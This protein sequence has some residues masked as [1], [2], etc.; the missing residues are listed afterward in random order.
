MTRLLLDA[1]L[2]PR[3]A[4]YLVDRF[5]LDVVSLLTLG[6]GHLDDLHV[7][8]FAKQQRR[9]LITFDA[10]FGTLYHRF[11]RGQVGII[12]LRLAHQSADSANRALERF[13]VD[14]MANTIALERSLELIDETRLRV[15]SEP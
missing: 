14:P 1:N 6:L 9:I 4:S 15:T 2:S 5:E 10:G 7:I 13:F 11:E 8:E 3:T 12:V